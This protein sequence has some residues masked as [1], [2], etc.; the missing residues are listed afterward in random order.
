MNYEQANELFVYDPE[1]GELRNRVDR[2]YQAKAGT[3]AGGRRGEG[4]SY[5]EIRG[6]GY[7]IHRV[8][9]LL[10]H[11]VWPAAQIDHVN[12]VRTDNR[13]ANLREATQSENLYN[14]GAQTNNTTGF[15]GV[16]W[17]KHHRKYK[18]QIMVQGKK[19]NLGHF[20]A[21]EAAYA[22]YQSAAHANHGAFANPGMPN[23]GEN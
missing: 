4:Y 7:L 19:I 17:D 3:L 6:K 21:P 9:W 13:L 11:G 18:A 16:C 5:V 22:S 23:M 15:K 2:G 12:G 1:T 10:T 8:A 20:A 14:R